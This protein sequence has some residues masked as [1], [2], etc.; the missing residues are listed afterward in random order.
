MKFIDVLTAMNY[1]CAIG[2]GWLGDTILSPSNELP[3]Q[4]IK[5]LTEEEKNATINFSYVSFNYT[6]IFVLN[7][8]KEK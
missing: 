3:E 6:L 7:P 8:P 4:A 1:Y 5:R 2:W